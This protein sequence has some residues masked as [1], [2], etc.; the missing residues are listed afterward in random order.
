MAERKKMGAKEALS[1]LKSRLIVHYDPKSPEA[2]AYR[3]LR[4][5]IGYADL[6]RKGRKILITS[7]RPSEGKTITTA[8]LAITIAE[9]GKNVLVIDT[10]MRR[11]T[12]HNIFGLDKTPGLT[13]I[14]TGKMSWDKAL[15]PSG[16][17]NLSIITSGSIP[18]N[19]SELV[20]SNK[21]E[22][23]LEDLKGYFDTFI[24][25]CASILAVTDATIIGS[26]VDGVLLVIMAERTPRDAVQRAM[27]LLNNAKAHVLGV[28]FNRVEMRSLHPY[29]YYYDY[30]EKE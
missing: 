30:T 18:P 28:I 8:N 9:I 20:G 21:M 24:F 29:Y 13:E 3:I 23:L 27:T 11:P 5:N 19:P 14:L 10:D 1:D 22:K 16:I 12:L 2:E 25:D 17:K 26:L 4:T 7:S 6:P 15:K